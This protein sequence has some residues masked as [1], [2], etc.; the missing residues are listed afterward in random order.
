MSTPKSGIGYSFRQ[1]TYI[2]GDS[3]L[4][5]GKNLDKPGRETTWKNCTMLEIE[6]HLDRRDTDA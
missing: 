2:T 3:Q 6:N 1:A 4:W 5:N